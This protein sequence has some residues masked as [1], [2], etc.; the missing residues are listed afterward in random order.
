MKYFTN[1]KHYEMTTEKRISNI[2]F[3]FYI[4]MPLCI[5]HIAISCSL[6]TSFIRIILYLWSNGQSE[7]TI[8]CQEAL[9]LLIFFLVFCELSTNKHKTKLVTYVV[10][11]NRPLF[12]FFFFLLGITRQLWSSC[13][14]IWWEYSYYW[15][16]LRAYHHSASYI[17]FP[18][19]SLSP[20]WLFWKPNT[21]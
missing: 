8:F 18:L 17:L 2:S 11:S 14:Q 1:L 5:F 21:A 4:I 19:A 3:I 13:L 20:F 6:L 9:Q 15:K 7:V 10:R 12:F 16:A